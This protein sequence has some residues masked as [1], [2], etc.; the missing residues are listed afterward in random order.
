MVGKEAGVWRQSGVKWSWVWGK[1]AWGQWVL[2]SGGKSSLRSSKV[3]LVAPFVC[4]DRCERPLGYRLSSSWRFFSLFFSRIDVI[5][6]WSFPE[7]KI[8]RWQAGQSGHA[9]KRTSSELLRKELIRNEGEVDVL[10][11]RRVWGTMPDVAKGRHL[12]LEFLLFFPTPSVK[13]A[14]NRLEQIATCHPQNSSC[15]IRILFSFRFVE[16]WTK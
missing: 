1:R 13:L 14:T 2:V 11:E 10:A 15:V 7:I 6:V 3:R 8:V 9:G 12:N 5:F 4:P 16:K